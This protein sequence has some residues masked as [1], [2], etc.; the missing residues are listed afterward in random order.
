MNFIFRKE[1]QRH[2]NPYFTTVFWFIPVSQQIYEWINLQ[3]QKW[4]SDWYKF[5]IKFVSTQIVFLSIYCVC[6]LQYIW[7]T[8]F[9]VQGFA[10]I[11]P[12]HAWSPMFHL[13]WN[14]MQHLWWLHGWDSL[15]VSSHVC[16]INKKEWE[17]IKNTNLSSYMQPRQAVWLFLS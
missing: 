13:A 3:G 7:Y 11:Q 17:N 9:S 4:V 16:M 5:Q 6:V 8:M 10:E 14:L 2:R 12:V 15:H 1:T